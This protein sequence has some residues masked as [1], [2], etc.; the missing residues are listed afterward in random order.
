MTADN[1]TTVLT[2]ADMLEIDGLHAFD[3][4]LSE[5]KLQITAMDGRAEKRWT[6]SLEQVEQA[7][8]DQ[9]L[10][11]WTL[12]GDSGEHRL[13]CMSAITGNNNDEDDEHDDA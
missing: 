3:F 13:I 9:T 6:F 5:Q 1:L 8:F 7:T 4:E 12:T 11:S 10:Q 2:T